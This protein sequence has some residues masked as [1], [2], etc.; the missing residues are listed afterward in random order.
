MLF[1]SS[2][3]GST[4]FS[5][6]FGVAIV[7]VFPELFTNTN[8]IYGPG[9]TV[10]YNLIPSTRFNNINSY[11]SPSISVAYLPARNTYSS[12]NR[13]KVFN[14]VHP[15]YSFS[16]ASR[17]KNIIVPTIIY[18]FSFLPAS[19]TQV[20]FSINRTHS[21]ISGSRTHSYTSIHSTATVLAT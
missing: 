9:L 12:P 18:N 4:G 1:G 11:Y 8:V 17:T 15:L 21:Y 5:N 16:P 13:D 3:L 20:G 14:A 6:S 2:P 10:N 19:R 7:S